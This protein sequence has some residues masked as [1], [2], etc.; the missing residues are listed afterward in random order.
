MDREPNM[1][2]I[3]NLLSRTVSDMFTVNCFKILIKDQDY[4]GRVA[5]LLASLI[6]KL[7]Q[8]G[9]L[10]PAQSKVKRPSQRYSDAHRLSG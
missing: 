7:I 1:R 10:L 2:L 3:R 6:D 8:S 9:D 5:E 4:A